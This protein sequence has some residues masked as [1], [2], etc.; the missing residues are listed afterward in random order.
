MKAYHYLLILAV[1]IGG[2]YFYNWKKEPKSKKEDKNT[3]G[4][5]AGENDTPDVNTQPVKKIE[6]ID[7]EQATEIVENAEECYIVITKRQSILNADGETYAIDTDTAIALKEAGV[8][9]KTGKIKKQ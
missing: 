5:A 3:N 6:T 2:W 9:T 8:E 1:I 4:N 7:L